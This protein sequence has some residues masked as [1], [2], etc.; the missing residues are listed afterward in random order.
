MSRLEKTFWIDNPSVK[1]ARPREARLANAM[2]ASVAGVGRI[3]QQ[4]RAGHVGIALVGLVTLI[5]IAASTTSFSSREN[6]GPAQELGGSALLFQ[7]QNEGFFR[8]VEAQSGPLVGPAIN[9]SE[10]APETRTYHTYD[11]ALAQR[12]PGLVAN[13]GGHHHQNFLVFFSGHQGSSWLL[14]MIGSA[15]GV[16]VPGFEPL[17]V[18]N[19]TAAQKLRF[20]DL[21]FSLPISEDAYAIWVAEIVD[22]GRQSGIRLSYTDLPTYADVAA[23]RAAGFKIRPYWGH[24]TGFRGLDLAEVKA[25]L[26]DRDVSLVLT[27]RQNYLKAAASWYRAREVGV[28]Q[29]TRQQSADFD[30]GQ[31]VEFDLD[32]FQEWV[33]FVVNAERELKDAVSFFQRPTLTVSYE[34]LA[35]DPIGATG[36]VAK[37]LG[38][39]GTR[40]PASAKFRKTGSD[41]LRVMVSNFEELCERYWV[42]PYRWMLGVESCREAGAAARGARRDEA[43][44]MTKAAALDPEA[45]RLAK[46]IAFPSATNPK[47]CFASGWADGAQGCASRLHQHKVEAALRARH[48]R[49][50]VFFKHVHKAG[51]T[52][53][54]QHASAFVFTETRPLP[55]NSGWGTDCVPQEAFLSRPPQSLLLSSLLRRQPVDA[56]ALTRRGAWLGGACFFGH[57]TP[58]AQHALPRAFPNLGFVASEGPLPDELALNLDYPLITMLRDPFDRL[59]SGEYSSPLSSFLYAKPSGTG[60][61]EERPGSADALFSSHPCSPQVVLVHEATLPGH[62]RL[63]LL[64]IRCPRKRH[65]ERVVGLLSGQLGDE[66]APGVSVPVRQGPSTGGGGA[67]ASEEQ[68]GGL[69]H[70]LGLG[71]AGSG[72]AGARGGP[73]VG[74]AGG[75]GDR[76]G[77]GG[78]AGQ[79]G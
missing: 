1:D 22:L 75:R 49:S 36:H 33:D 39:G 26:D 20:L 43:A 27:T 50:P 23:T 24:R 4:S 56:D 73:G 34:E 31:K 65:P 5:L 54:C 46:A 48:R 63:D 76:N 7:E 8:V 55:A 58:S 45:S 52:T 32:R 16:Y 78:A 69:H 19:A 44:A 14:D 30:A 21:T 38:L 71:G 41:S 18:L 13:A 70:C 51:G 35:L 2:A 64:F 10:S 53:L 62:S 9:V 47:D 68:A 61:I 72:A 17:E 40:A 25:I 57:L 67:A 77:G 60:R 12:D 79:R 11:R 74:G 42:T 3:L 15:P 6:P 37:F 29:F 66:D 59:V 28:N